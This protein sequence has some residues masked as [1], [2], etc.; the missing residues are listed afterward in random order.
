MTPRRVSAREAIAAVPPGVRVVIGPACGEPT[1]LVEA[2]VSD[3][4]RLKGAQVHVGLHLGGYPFLRREP[5]PPLRLATWLPTAD[6]WKVATADQV[7]V[8][9][10]RWGD[11]D[12]AL[13]TRG[14]Q[15]ALVQVAPP[16]EHGR[17]SLGMS[18]SYTLDVV[19][20]ADLVIAEVSDETPRTR[21]AVLRAEDIDL[22]CDADL[23]ARRLEAAGPDPTAETI[24]SI[25]AGLVPD[26][27][28]VQAGVGV[29]PRF[30]VR[31]LGRR[32][33]A[34]SLFGLASDELVD[35]TS[36]VPIEP[37]GPSAIIGEA[38][39]GSRLAAHLHENPDVEFRPA[40]YTH[41]PRVSSRWRRFVT[42]NSGLEIDLTGQVNAESVNGRQVSGP[43]G[44][45][46]F[47]EGSRLAP[48]S[49]SILALPSTAANGRISRIVPR[50]SSP[51]TIPRFM[52]RTVVT[53]FGVADLFG[54][55]LR[56][57]AASL[58]A[59]A[60]PAH[61]DGLQAALEEDR[62]GAG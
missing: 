50:L 6:L 38:L 5:G 3:A 54:Q 58:I 31:E 57:R 4:A 21:G 16:D 48:D 61:R 11:I 26:G 23:P 14:M 36:L 42:V 53:E 13:A 37:G 1:T 49:R 15:A 25:V 39:G 10:L 17:F 52:A 43:G 7:D 41:D 30:V 33:A 55:T 60:H 59:I 28:V 24:A 2:L 51:V 40:S 20:H 27:A 12:A 8:I 9:P 45:P 22:L 19:R 47:I 35:L 34:F 29:V 62:H 56:E 44:G 46:D 32:G 18:A